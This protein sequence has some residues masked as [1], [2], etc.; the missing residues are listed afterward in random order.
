MEP[1]D[2]AGAFGGRADGSLESPED[3]PDEI[4]DSLFAPP[5]QEA[6]DA[7]GPGTSDEGAAGPQVELLVECLR[8]YVEIDEFRNTRANGAPCRC[9]ECLLC[10]S[11]A[12][13]G[14]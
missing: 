4:S 6:T 1:V 9:G 5:H 13:L 2:A 8:R 12:A 11:R 7:A 14:R 3:T 10:R